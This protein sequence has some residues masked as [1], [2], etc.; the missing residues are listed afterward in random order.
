MVKKDG[1]SKRLAK[2]GRGDDSDDVV[3]AIRTLQSEWAPPKTPAFSA[4][5]QRHRLP[6]TSVLNFLA[7]NA[8]GA[9]S[10]MPCVMCAAHRGRAFKAL[11]AAA[12]E[13]EVTLFGTPPDGRAGQRIAPSAFDVPLS[14]DG[15]DGIGPDWA[16]VTMERFV[17]LRQSPDLWVWR[18]VHVHRESLVGWLEK[19]S[20]KAIPP[21]TRKIGPRGG[22]PSSMDDIEAE[23]DRWIDNGT[24]E[25]KRELEHWTPRE[26]RRS[27]GRIARALAAWCKTAG[28]DTSDATIKK[29]LSPKLD[30]ALNLL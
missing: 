8:P 10:D 11:Y 20:T 30:D 18:D 5:E 28:G 3:A 19:L 13:A 17:E 12:R 25:L 29:A 23:L 27:K 22:R 1:T 6:L 16:E 7:F 21:L 9:P 26:T 15:D 24:K 4:L 14:P 2:T